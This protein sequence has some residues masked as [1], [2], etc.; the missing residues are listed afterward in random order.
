MSVGATTPGGFVVTRAPST[1]AGGAT[2]PFAFARG[3]SLVALVAFGAGQWMRM[4]EPV[5]SQRATYAVLIAIAA[6]GG[7]LATRLLPHKLQQPAAALVSLSVVALALV[8]GGVA[9]ELVTPGRIPDLVGGIERGLTAIPGARVPYRGVDEWTRIVLA[10]GGTVFAALAAIIAFWPARTRTGLPIPA[11]ILLVAL[12]VVPAVALN[13]DQGFGTGAVLS[14]LVLA[15]LRLE[16]LRIRDARAAAIATLGVGVVALLAAPTLDRDAPWFDYESWALSAAGSKSTTFDWEHDYGALDWPRDGREVLRVKAER[17]AYWKAEVLDGFDGS[18]WVRDPSVPTNEANALR[19]LPDDDGVLEKWAQ[20][21]KVN[22]RNLRTRTAVAAGTPLAFK[23]GRPRIIP[24]SRATVYTPGRT[25]RR[26][27]AYEALVYTPR[28]TQQQLGDAGT[29]YGRW[30]RSYLRFTSGAPDGPGGFAPAYVVDPAPFGSDEDGTA[31]TPGSGVP[32]FARPGEV[33]A[34]SDLSRTWALAQQLKRSSKDAH[35]FVR[36]VIRY[37]GSADF[38][39]T[40]TPPPA[41][42]TLEGF[43]FDARRGMCQQYSGA[44]ALMLRMGGVPA[45]V[46]T[47]FAPGT[48]DE[49]TGEY[50]VRDVDAHSWVEVWFPGYGWVTFDPTPSTAPPRSQADANALAAGVGDVRDLGVGKAAFDPR[51]AG[52][53]AGEGGGTPWVPIGLGAMLTALLAVAVVRHRRRP[54]AEGADG[55]LAELERALRRAGRNLG[56]GVTLTALERAFTTPAAA[57]YVRTLRE[58]RYRDESSAPTAA[59]RR[60]LRSELARGQGPIGRIRALWA[61]PPRLH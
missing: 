57:G 14:L 42:E 47:G 55:P 7:L 43:L 21:I 45:R 60:A 4:L 24:S 26:G 53:G 11:L 13:A 51:L 49:D 29:S 6:I 32:G 35:Q 17:S 38:S 33:L 25:L 9:D 28:P 59:Q 39:Y 56:P 22:V 52:T 58:Q 50:V 61:L 36:R 15:F 8:A 30:L 1:A 3:I 23:A 44:M 2:L 41:A 16:R 18:R 27:D 5:A 54:R 10:C 48:F 34:A 46:A 31:A 20:T 12:Y 37:L 40:E 19:Q